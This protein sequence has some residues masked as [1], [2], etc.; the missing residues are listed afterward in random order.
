VSE[1]PPDAIV[2]TWEPD[3]LGRIGELV[4]DRLQEIVSDPMTSQRNLI[5]AGRTVAKLIE[6]DLARA[7]LAAL[8]PTDPIPFADVVHRAEARSA[9]RRRE[10]LEASGETP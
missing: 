5:A 9:E 6:L 2:L 1:T 8:K 3:R 10:R 7:R 4:L